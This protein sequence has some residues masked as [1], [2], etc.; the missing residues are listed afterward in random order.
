MRDI[1][2]Q[3]LLRQFWMTGNLWWCGDCGW[4]N[5]SHAVWTNGKGGFWHH[6][7]GHDKPARTAVVEHKTED[8]VRARFKRDL[9]PLGNQGADCRWCTGECVGHGDF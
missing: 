7:D 1:P 8:E 4:I 5:S 3:A 9:P 6:C 2:L